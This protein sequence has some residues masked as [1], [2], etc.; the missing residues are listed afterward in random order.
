MLKKIQRRFVLSSLAAFSLVMLVLT[1]GINLMNYHQTR[2]KQERTL[3]GILEYEQVSASLSEEQR[4]PI[5]QMDWVENPEGEFTSRFFLVHCSVNG[6][7]S[8]FGN[9][10]I[11]SVDESD[12]DSYTR[13]VLDLGKDS[14]V[15]G[16]YRYRVSEAD[17]ELTIVFLNIADSARF[18]RTLLLISA[19]ILC[20]SILIV[21]ALVI[22]LSGAAMKPFLQNLERQ[23]RFITD[24]GH[25]LKTPITSISTS[26]DIL[27]LTTP[28]NEWVRNIQKQ[29]ERLAKLVA[30]LVTLSRLDE[31]V[32][33]PEKAVFSLSEAAWEAAEAMETL[34]SADGRHYTQSIEDHITTYGDRASIQK[35]LS[36]LLDNSLRYT[37]QNGEIR[38]SVV[39]KRHR[40]IIEVSNTCTLDRSLDPERLFDRFYRPDE[41]R[42]THTGGS[43]IGLAIA[44]EITEAHGGKI[45]AKISDAHMITFRVVLSSDRTGVLQH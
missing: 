10:Y 15:Y 38:F 29:S 44:R 20:G 36:V 1:A 40:I 32:P 41:S 6:S 17:G 37:P 34:A 23:K 8:V 14:G 9:E 43:G 11:S 30:E 35:L 18:C 19:L 39:Q 22:L 7:V 13:A 12:A 16:D 31:E 33:F 21:T 26:A 42:S 25:E 27:E 45:T 5:N 24:A 3:D 2:L 4:I 28:D